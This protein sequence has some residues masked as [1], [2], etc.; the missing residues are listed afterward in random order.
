M[1]ARHI[2]MAAAFALTVAGEAR[3]T[4][5]LTGHEHL[6]VTSHHVGGWLWH[7]STADIKLGGTVETVDVHDAAVV[8]VSGGRVPS[9]LHAYEIV[10]QMTYSNR[11][12]FCQ[13]QLL[14]YTSL[15]FQILIY[16]LFFSTHL[17]LL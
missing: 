5:W 9:Y 12:A 6:D 13:F 17:F 4:F 1:K 11:H 7:S 8:T 3:A 14:D 2:L 10:F 15:L 16:L